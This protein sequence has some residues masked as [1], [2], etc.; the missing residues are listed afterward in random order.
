MAVDGAAPFTVD[1]RDPH[2]AAPGGRRYDFAIDPAE[3][4][5]LL[6]GTDLVDLT[7]RQSPAID[8]WEAGMRRSRPWLQ[9]VGRSE[10]MGR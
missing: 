8:A 5:V 1:L 4:I 10:G 3:R 9:D 7:L 6:E 2:I